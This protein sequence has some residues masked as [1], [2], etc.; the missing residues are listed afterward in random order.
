MRKVAILLL[1][2]GMAGVLWGI[3][4]YLSIQLGRLL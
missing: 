1:W 4:I 2:L 3:I